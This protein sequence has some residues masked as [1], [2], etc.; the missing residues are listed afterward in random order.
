[1][2][3]ESDDCELVQQL[4]D[5]GAIID[6]QADVCMHILIM[7]KTHAQL[8]HNTHCLTQEDGSHPLHLAVI[9]KSAEMFHIV[10]LQYEDRSVDVVRDVR[11][12]I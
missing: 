6:I 12:M 4:L 7:C 9:S 3:G 11:I 5:T 8:P 2:K 1:M 10:L